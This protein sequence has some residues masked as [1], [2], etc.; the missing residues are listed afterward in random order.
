MARVGENGNVSRVLIMKTEKKRSVRSPG[1][2]WK[3]NI[4]WLLKDCS[5]WQDSQH[6]NELPVCVE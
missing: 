5:K 3:R 6:C 2:R 1:L 4:K